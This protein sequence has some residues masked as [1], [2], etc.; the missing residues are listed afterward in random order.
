[1]PALNLLILRFGQG[2]PLDEFDAGP[3]VD[4]RTRTKCSIVASIPPHTI[5]LEDQGGDE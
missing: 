2:V 5:N 1:M 3:N 4:L